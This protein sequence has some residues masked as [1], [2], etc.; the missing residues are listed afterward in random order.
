MLEELTKPGAM[1][2]QTAM[3]SQ[4]SMDLDGAIKNLKV[5]IKKVHEEM[6]DAM[7]VREKSLQKE[8]SDEV[9]RLRKEQVK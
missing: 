4:L 7:K 3:G 9:T 6:E 5:E 2:E 8:L 1:L